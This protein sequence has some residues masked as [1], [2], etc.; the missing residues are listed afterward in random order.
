MIL[1]EFLQ[2]HYIYIVFLLT[3]LS[4][5][6]HIL[7]GPAYLEAGL[8]FLLLLLLA[9]SRKYFMVKSS[10]P[11]LGWGFVRLAAALL[12]TLA[13]GVIGFWFLDVRQFGRNFHVGQ[14]VH[15]TLLFLSFVGSPGLNPQT[16]YAQWFLDSLYLI[17]AVGV[18]YGLYAVFRPVR[19]TLV[20]LPRDRELARKI[21]ENHGRHALDYFKIWPDKSL[22]FSSR[23]SAFL[24]YRVERNFAVVLADPV[25][26]QEEMERI[27][28]DTSKK[29][30]TNGSTWAWHPCP[31]FER[32]KTQVRKSELSTIF[33]SICVSYSALRG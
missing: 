2:D 6:L 19:Y 5:V 22:F 14:A 24:A 20:S 30:A 23:R 4:T 25:G 26:P 1:F 11:N 8:S 27:V 28:S 15:Q 10:T 32:E 18:L 9:M 33:F 29:R 16:R 13:Y 7:E 31:D 21:L 12:L 17:S 3:L